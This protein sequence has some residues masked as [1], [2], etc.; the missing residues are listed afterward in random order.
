M[1]RIAKTLCAIAAA[2]VAAATGAYAAPQNWRTYTDPVHGASVLVPAHLFAPVENAPDVPG[3]S[4]LTPD[5]RAR[6]AFAAWENEAGDTPGTFRDRLL[7]EG[8][9]PVLTYRPGGRS[10]FVLSGYRGDKIYYQKVIYS[11]GR[12]VVNAFAITYPTAERALYD[13][14]VER[15]EDNFRA[16]RRCRVR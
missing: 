8:D 10:W 11:C 2:A 16:G 5:G 15:M 14:V 6:V 12:R 7:R 1:K 3:Q 9:Y 4:F 13:P